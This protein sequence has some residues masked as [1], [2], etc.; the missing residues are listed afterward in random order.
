[1]KVDPTSTKA[2]GLTKLFGDYKAA[3]KDFQN[4]IQNG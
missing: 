2:K 3:V 1:L 4:Y